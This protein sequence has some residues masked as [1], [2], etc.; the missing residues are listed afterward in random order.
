MVLETARHTGDRMKI[1]LFTDAYFP[2]ISGVSLS[3]E[4][5]ATELR[6]LGHEVYV[7]ALYHEEAKP[8]PYVIR[9][10]GYRLPMKGMKE[11]RISK[12]T[13]R[14]VK[15]MAAYGFDLVHCHTE[16]TMG[17]LG[18]RTARKL[19]V[20]V[21]HTYHTMYEDYVHFVSK[22]LVIPL[23]FAAKKYFKRFADSADAVIFPTIK[24]KRTFDGYGYDGRGAIIPTG[25]YLEKFAPD[26]YD[27]AE[28]KRLR[29]ACGIDDDQ[30]V[31]LFLGRVSREKSIG[32]LIELFARL[33]ED[34]TVLL[35]VG[36]GPD[37][38]HFGKQVD[39]LGIRDKVRFTGMIPPER[40]GSYY[41]IADLFVNFS[42][43]ET[44]GLTYLEALASG[45]PLVVK[46]D[47]NLEGVVTNDVNGFTF[48]T[49]DTFLDLV[50][51]LHNNPEKTAALAKQASSALEEF[52]ARTYAMRVEDI[53]KQLHQG[54]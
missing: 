30:F 14:H 1:G 11:Y 19:G 54:G 5:L 2:I 10:R 48:H 36:D 25:I 32:R 33:E 4:T 44:Q 16:F 20:P 41:R 50:S 17:R 9:M 26:R 40:V 7:I 29:H 13:R 47:D 27:P 38:P 52:S 6:K 42:V 31:L 21:V 12:V 22:A 35:I 3:V 18:R 15:E 51:R 39:R 8:D 28:L 23:R 43:T 45:L 34:K 37:R 24:V 46:Y 49:D 53:Y